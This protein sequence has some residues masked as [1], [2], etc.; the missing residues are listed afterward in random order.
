MSNQAPP[1]DR[2]RRQLSEAVWLYFESRDPLVVETL[3]EEARANLHELMERAPAEV[4]R[5]FLENYLL[6]EHHGAAEEFLRAEGEDAALEGLL[7]DALS[8]YLHLAQEWIIEAAAFFSWMQLE[9]REWFRP[10]VLS[11]EGLEARRGERAFFLAFL[12]EA[13]HNGPDESGARTGR[14]GPGRD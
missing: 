11:T 4:R 2:A 1:L 5:G 3:A 6:P 12:Q 10:E 8:A 13:E 7:F 9:K 14:R